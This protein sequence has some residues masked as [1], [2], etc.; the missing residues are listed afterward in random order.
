[1]K[2]NTELIK[3][4]L[5][6]YKKD[7]LDICTSDNITIDTLSTKIE[8]IKDNVN[9]F[10]TLSLFIDD[11]TFV[12]ETTALSLVSERLIENQFDF[13]ENKDFKVSLIDS[14]CNM[15]IDLNTDPTP[16]NDNIE[17]S[18]AD[19][20][21]NK[22]TQN[23]FDDN[24]KDRKE[25]TK[26]YNDLT[27]K[28]KVDLL[29]ESANDTISSYFHSPEDM[30]KYLDYMSKFYKYSP[31]NVALIENQFNGARAVGSFKFWK[32]N[33]F[34]VNKGEKGIKILT[35]AKATYIILDDENMKQLKY[36]TKEE[37]EKVKKGIL[38]TTQKQFYKTGYV[39][40]ISQTNA[41]SEDL[42][43]LFPNKWLDGEVKDYDKMY[44]AMEKIADTIGVKII[45]PTEEMGVAKGYSLP[46]T[47][48]VTLNP[49]NSQLQNVKTL[50]H[51]LAHAKLHTLERRN[52][53]FKQEREY[54]AEMVAY[55]TC[56]YFGI[57]TSDYSLD[58]LYGWTKNMD[59]D[60]SIKIIEEVKETSTEYIQIIEDY[61][62]NDP[63]MDMSYN[64]DEKEKNIAEN[65]D[66]IYVKFTSSKSNTIEKDDI[67][68]FDTANELVRVLNEKYSYLKTP[69]QTNFELHIDEN[70]SN[71]FYSGSIELGNEN[72][73][74]LKSNLDR[75]T[76]KDFYTG[77]FDI[78]DGEYNNLKEYLYDNSGN[79]TKEI[80]SE[81]LGIKDKKKNQSINKDIDMGFEL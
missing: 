68:D 79:S 59:L 16:S 42:P 46:S 13:F 32:D 17:K 33:G 10:S 54:Q 15:G 31:R 37:K 28:E 50:L 20:D 6:D 48:E 5:N 40:D 34:T 24:S 38:Q 73:Y 64:D 21:I 74:D 56:S 66:N 60:E 49:R 51:E 19:N 65:I 67:Y 72:E 35:P 9:T 69:M 23:I 4:T 75:T 8:S 47:K 78:G 52:N 76:N 81:R 3:K 80:L 57:D 29:V 44:K 36:A 62:N 61:F 12:K 26:S 25:Q 63:S 43:K 7:I 11:P 53:Y 39:F 27:P 14:L 45:E 22:K 1:M 58:Y 18:I 30:K 71:P 41:T 70:C 55:T 77:R 2:I